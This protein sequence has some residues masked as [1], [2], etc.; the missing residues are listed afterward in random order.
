MLQRAR[1]PVPRSTDDNNAPAATPKASESAIGSPTSE[2]DV[3]EA[4]RERDEQYDR[5]V[6]NM[7]V[8]ESLRDY[9]RGRLDRREYVVEEQQAEEPRYAK[10]ERDENA[11]DVDVKS[12]KSP[13]PESKH[14][15]EG[16]SLYPILR[17]PSS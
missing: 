4:T 16:S 5:W 8:I 17:M 3:S 7:R 12:P 14:P 6:E 10:R 11:M 1:G 13:A 9:V 2:S 15:R